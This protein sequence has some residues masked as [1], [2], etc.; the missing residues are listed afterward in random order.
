MR[1]SDKGPEGWVLFPALLPDSFRNFLYLSSLTNK[2]RLYHPSSLLS[3]S[4]S[5]DEKGFIRL[6]HNQGGKKV[7]EKEVALD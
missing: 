7:K 1:G 3:T 4:L 6:P 5:T 2:Y